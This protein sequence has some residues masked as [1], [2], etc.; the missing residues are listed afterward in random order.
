MTDAPYDSRNGTRVIDDGSHTVFTIPKFSVVSA[1][2]IEK[3]YDIR[4]I[5][6]DPDTFLVH[7]QITSIVQGIMQ[8][9][10]AE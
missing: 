1:E 3:E 8:K 10:G 4:L 2:G 6:T 5:A 9:A 7:V